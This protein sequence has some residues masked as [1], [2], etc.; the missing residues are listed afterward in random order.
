[1]LLVRL[2]ARAVKQDLAATYDAYGQT[3]PC[4]GYVRTREPIRHRYL[5]RCAHRSTMHT[6]RSNARRRG[7]STDDSSRP[8]MCPEAG[9]GRAG[10]SRR[11]AQAQP[12]LPVQPAQN[13]MVRGPGVRPEHQINNG[14]STRAAL[15]GRGSEAASAASPPV[16]RGTRTTRTTFTGRRVSMSCQPARSSACPSRARATDANYPRHG[17]EARRG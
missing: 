16:P 7:G 15:G 1:M 3:T 11:Y 8:G 4:S 9:Q 6:S 17:C 2:E 10:S 5:E 14:Q 12:R 13:R